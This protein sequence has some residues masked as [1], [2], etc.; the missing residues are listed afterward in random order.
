[1]P[2]AAAAS[3]EKNCTISVVP[4]LAPSMTARAGTRSTRPPA[5]KPVIMRPVAVLL[6]STAVA[7]RPAAKALNRL[8]NAEARTRRSFGPKA[9]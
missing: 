9:R 4:T 3:K 7:P 5:A 2:A 6:W 8:L 1:M